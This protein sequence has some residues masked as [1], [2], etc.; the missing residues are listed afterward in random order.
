MTTLKNT[1]RLQSHLMYMIA[2]ETTIG[3]M[4]RGLLSK[5]SAHAG[6]TALLTDF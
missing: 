1:N 3:Q 6:V 5:V 2:I 4:L